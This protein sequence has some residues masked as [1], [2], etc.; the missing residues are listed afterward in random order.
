[1]GRTTRRIANGESDTG[2]P[3]N[4]RLSPHATAQIIGQAGADARQERS[5]NF[6]IGCGVQASS[7]EEKRDCFLR[8]GGAARDAG[9]ECA[10][11]SPC[12]SLPEAAA[13]INAFW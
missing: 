13:S 1:M 10:R 9:G 5:R 3:K 6:G 11:N 8:E 2:A 4:Q 7:I 12:G